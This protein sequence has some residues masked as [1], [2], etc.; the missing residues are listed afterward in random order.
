MK[1]KILKSPIYYKVMHG[2]GEGE[3]EEIMIDLAIRNTQ[4]MFTYVS[5]DTQS[6]HYIIQFYDLKDVWHEKTGK[7]ITFTDIEIKKSKP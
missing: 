5:N 3:I 2:E 6:E 1:N 4:A 7:K